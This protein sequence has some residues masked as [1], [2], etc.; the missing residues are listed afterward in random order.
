MKIKNLLY[1]CQIL[2][3]ADASEENRQT[4]VMASTELSS[5]LRLVILLTQLWLCLTS[6]EIELLQSTLCVDMKD[7]D[8]VNI[9]FYLFRI[10]LLVPKYSRRHLLSQIVSKR[11]Q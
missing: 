3:L 2:A 11:S 6:E 10:I 5:G 7:L 8:V 9:L 4:L 1:I